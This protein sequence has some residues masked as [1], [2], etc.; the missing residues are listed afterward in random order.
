MMQDL[1]FNVTNI[2]GAGVFAMIYSRSAADKL[3]RGTF[4]IIPNKRDAIHFQ[5]Q[6]SLSQAGQSG[7]FQIRGHYDLFSVIVTFNHSALSETNRSSTQATSISM[8][9]ERPVIELPDS[10][11]P[12]NL[13]SLVTS[14]VG[15]QYFSERYSSFI[16]EIV[17]DE[18]TQH[19]VPDQR[20][21]DLLSDILNGG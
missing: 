16:Q 11:T 18:M 13:V 14:D 7:V 9:I 12:R 1:S 3:V 21:N 20:V 5:G 15:R 2:Y 19:V 4:S 10:D 8:V 6:V 17:D